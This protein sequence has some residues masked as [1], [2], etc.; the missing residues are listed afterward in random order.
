MSSANRVSDLF[1]ARSLIFCYSDD[2]DEFL[3]KMQ[4]ADITLQNLPNEVYRALCI[5]AA[6]H[7]R[8][9]EAEIRDILTAAVK[10]AH[11]VRMGDELAALGRRT[12]L[13][14]DDLAFEQDKT[15]ADPMSFE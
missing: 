15:P 4:M 10:P 7:G 1:I 12:E 11:R 2:G 8:S 13:G 3:S 9:T 5:R 14:D 6:M